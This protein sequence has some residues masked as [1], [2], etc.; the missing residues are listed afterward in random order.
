MMRS[1]RANSD[2]AKRARQYLETGAITMVAHRVDST[3]G[4]EEVHWQIVSELA[5]RGHPVTVVAGHFAQ[6]PLSHTLFYRVRGP[7]RPSTLRHS[8]FLI[9]SRSVLRQHACGLIHLCGPA[10]LGGSDIVTFHFCHK[11]YHE[12]VGISRAARQS[13]IY[14]ANAAA[15]SSMAR[16][17]EHKVMTDSRHGIPVAVSHGLAAELHEAYPGSEA[18]TSVIPNA[19]SPG[20]VAVSA[21]AGSVARQELGLSSQSLI[22]LFAGGDWDRKGLWVAVNA[23]AKTS[24]WTLLVVGRGDEARLLS[25]AFELGISDRVRYLGFRSDIARWY[26]ASDVLVFPTGY[27]AAPLV[28]LEACAAGLPL[29]AT[30]VS[31]IS[32]LLAAGAG[33]DVQRSAESVRD[34]LVR[35]ADEATRWKHSQAARAA[36]SAQTWDAV[37]D[38]YERLYS[39]VAEA[40]SR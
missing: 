18:R 15:F 11:Y 40:N 28:G 5:S 25:L 21:D 27:E 38:Q 30:P 35:M 24:D 34:G 31:G 16:R 26:A 17:G 8:S 2:A 22:A 37:V 19:W 12:H 1:S 20:R 10:Y 3:G 7:K 4:Q 14:R 33:I 13:P 23:V 9:D 39:Q 36:A 6:P 29:V 32:E